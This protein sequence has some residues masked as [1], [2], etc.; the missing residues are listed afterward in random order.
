MTNPEPFVNKGI[1]QA[2]LI[3]A[4]MAGA[5]SEYVAR[6]LIVDEALRIDPS[7]ERY[8]INNALSNGER[9]VKKLFTAR[10][11][12]GKRYSFRL[13]ALGHEKASQISLERAIA[14]H[15]S[16]LDNAI[17]ELETLITQ[18]PIPVRF[19]ET[20]MLDDGR[21]IVED[22]QGNVYLADFQYIGKKGIM[23][24]PPRQSL[25]G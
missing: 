24:D 13:T 19:E 12:N 16:S 3:G 21:S 23:H 25:V 10:R 8:Q 22:I 9:A 7:L 15:P 5:D 20:V 17:E 4:L 2:M 11:R 14:E 18:V 6:D 1:N